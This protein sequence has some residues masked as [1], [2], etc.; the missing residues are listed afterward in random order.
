[1]S[2]TSLVLRSL[3]LLGFILAMP[4]LA[5]PSVAR[6]ADEFLYGDSS[7]T[8]AEQQPLT[9]D[10]DASADAQREVVQ[11]VLETPLSE[12]A[13]RQTEGGRGLDAVATHP[14]EMPPSPDFPVGPFVASPGDD[15]KNA[16]LLDRLGEIRQRLEDLG[17][18]Y[19]RVET[20]PGTGQY[21]CECRMVVAPGSADTETFE[22]SG[23]DATGV[24]EQVLKTIEAWRSNRASRSP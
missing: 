2:R 20:L 16:V 19:I 4:V 13:R 8:S 7:P 22:A 11:A 23:T 3:F 6:W 17:A 18:E 21:H 5:L 15:P 14:P 9:Q 1:M 12:A 24:A 10:D